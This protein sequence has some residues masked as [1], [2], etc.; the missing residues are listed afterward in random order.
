MGFREIRYLPTNYVLYCFQFYLVIN[1]GQQTI[2]LVSDPNPCL[3]VLFITLPNRSLHFD[4]ATVSV[5]P[6]RFCTQV[7]VNGSTSE[8]NDRQVSIYFIWQGTRYKNVAVVVMVS[9]PIKFET[10]HFI[11]CVFPLFGHIDTLIKRAEFPNSGQ[12]KEP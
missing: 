9:N 10:I 8:A 7:F 6:S 11:F 12:K 4:H 1:L 2:R 3:V 5:A